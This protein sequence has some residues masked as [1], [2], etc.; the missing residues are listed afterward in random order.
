[1]IREILREEIKKALEVLGLEVGAGEIV[2]EYPSNFDFGDYSTNVAMV[3]AKKNGQSPKNL[4]RQ[5]VS[6]ILEAG[7]GNIK[8]A[9]VA[10]PGFINIYL[11]EKFFVENLRKIIS[12]EGDYG[13]GQILNGKKVMVEYTDPNPFKEFHIGHLMSNTIG[14]ALSRI[15]EASGAE[16]KRACYQGDI[17]L[18]VA[19]AI[20]GYRQNQKKTDLTAGDWGKFYAIGAKAYDESEDLKKEINEI[21]RQIYERSD[22]AIN[23][24]YD[25]GRKVSLAYFETIYRRLGTNFDFYFFES[26]TGEIGKKIVEEGLV[27]N[28]FEKSD[29]A[30]VFRA[31]NYD[32][33]LHTRV[34]INS[35]GLPTYEAKELGLAELK[36]EKYPYDI[37]VSVTGNE[38]V[39]YFKVVLK[40]LEQLRPELVTKIKHVAHGMLRLPTGKMSSRTGDVVTAELLISEAKKKVSEKIIDRE[41]SS[42]EKEKITEAVAIGALK[43]SILK[44]SAGRDIVFDFDKSLSFE[45]DSGPYLQYSYARAKSVLAKVGEFSDDGFKLKAEISEVEKVL[46]RF[47]EVVE[48]AYLELAPQHLATY[49]IS[50]AG[51]FNS[52]YSK[53][54]IIGSEA[55]SYRLTLTEA[56][57]KVLAK[58]LSL[59]GIPVLEKM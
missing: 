17:G 42:E 9:Q 58:G 22:P 13:L 15:I 4:A 37:S 51:V 55:E 21:N 25:S 27:K 52:Y 26:E 49:L 8:D 32:S 44:Q 10:G 36:H 35:L 20:W 16:I 54:K 3:L 2:L 1:M 39:G 41:L 43:Y 28:V 6:K 46:S 50:L 7:N 40:A 12:V 14:E 5:I 19:K 11:S 48:R 33:H 29:G 23:E 56:V 47:P 18:H 45:G 53:N 24:A 57:S 38:I 31:E 59:L 30:I 34:F